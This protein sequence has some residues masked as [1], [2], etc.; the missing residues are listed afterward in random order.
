M[1]WAKNE[2]IPCVN[3]SNTGNAAMTVSAIV[4]SGTSA[5]SEVYASEPARPKQPSPTNRRP[6]WFA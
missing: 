6:T 3:C 1:F 4:R 2:S 5:S